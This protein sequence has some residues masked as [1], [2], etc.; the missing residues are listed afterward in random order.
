MRFANIHHLVAAFRL[1][2][3]PELEMSVDGEGRAEELPRAHI[4]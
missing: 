2:R 4:Y 1:H 3:M